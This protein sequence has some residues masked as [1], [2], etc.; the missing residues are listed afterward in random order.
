[1]VRSPAGRGRVHRPHLEFLET[2]ELLDGGAGGPTR[3]SA[4]GRL[5]AGSGARSTRGDS[6]RGGGGCR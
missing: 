2:R 3:A 6:R 5:S 4:A 1:M